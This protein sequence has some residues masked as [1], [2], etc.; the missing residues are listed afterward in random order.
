SG[1]APGLT[2]GDSRYG[3]A[4]SRFHL[5]VSEITRAIPEEIARYIPRGLHQLVLV[6]VDDQRQAIRDLELREDRGQVMAHGVV[7]DRKA[8][9]DRLVGKPR[10]DQRHD[11]ALARRERGDLRAFRVVAPRA[12][13]PRHV[14]DELG[15]HHAIDPELAGVHLA[16][17]VDEMLARARL[18]HD[19]VR[20]FEP[21]TYGSAA[22]SARGHHEY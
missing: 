22:I 8:S 5:A 15:R 20:A 17:R 21:Q 9:C 12:R 2:G 19:A 7:A 4:S 13:K 18:E 14:G 10:G 11:V 3:R 1:P 16:D 6:R